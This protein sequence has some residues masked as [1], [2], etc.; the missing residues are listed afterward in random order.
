MRER[1]LRSWHQA[2]IEDEDG[3]SNVLNVDIARKEL[4]IGG[5]HGTARPG[6][7]ALPVPEGHQRADHDER[8]RWNK[9]VKNMEDNLER[10]TQQARA[11]G[12]MSHNPSSSSSAEHGRNIYRITLAS[13]RCN[14]CFQHGHFARECPSD[15]RKRGLPC[16]TCGNMGHQ[17]EAC[18]I[19]RGASA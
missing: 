15:R 19:Q 18:C 3:N 6:A 9:G 11:D 16:Q 12:Y 5:V 17:E 1:A 4:Y 13:G 10:M 7:L 14:F 8:N 2:I